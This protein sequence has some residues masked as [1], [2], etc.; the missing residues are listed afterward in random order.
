[1]SQEISGHTR[2]AHEVNALLY[3]NRCE[4]LEAQR[5]DLLAA[6]ET[7]E[8]AII[9]AT[10]AQTGREFSERDAPPSLHKVRAAIAK[11]KG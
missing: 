10:E 9:D 8:R 11:A 6:L 2:G 5:D 7:A 1:M 3:A 4:E